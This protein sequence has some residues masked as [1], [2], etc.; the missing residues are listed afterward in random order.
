MRQIA[1]VL[2]AL[3][4]M[5]HSAMAQT[6]QTIGQLTTIQ[7][8]INQLTLEIENRKLQVLEAKAQNNQRSALNHEAELKRLNATLSYRRQEITIWQ[9]Q[10]TFEKQAP[11]P[12]PQVQAVKVRI[13][14]L[15]FEKGYLSLQQNQASQAGND[16]QAE[17]FG[18]QITK[19]QNEIQSRTQEIRVIEM[20][21]KLAA[22]PR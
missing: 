14:Q 22:P 4:A 18:L 10:A 1:L 8:H 15:T 3:V 13:Q 11:N 20:R 7:T 21:A 12:N 5:R 17:Q 2:I 6:A 9:Q 16:K 19:R